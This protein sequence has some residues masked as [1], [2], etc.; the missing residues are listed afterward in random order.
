MLNTKHLRWTRE[1]E[2]G[3]ISVC[4]IMHLLSFLV[5]VFM[6]IPMG[7]IAVVMHTLHMVLLLG[8]LV[9]GESWDGN[10][11]PLDKNLIQQ[12]IFEIPLHIN[13]LTN[14]YIKIVDKSVC[15]NIE[16]SY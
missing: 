12:D 14:L 3:I 9:P 1:R 13:L 6:P 8:K 7:Y 2:H 11:V 4:T 10:P 5:Q 16:Q 15:H